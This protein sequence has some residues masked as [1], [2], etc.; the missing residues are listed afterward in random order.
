MG[1]IASLFFATNDRQIATGALMKQ[2]G[3]GQ[4]VTLGLST[5]S[6]PRG[7]EAFRFF[8]IG[9]PWDATQTP[10]ADEKPHARRMRCLR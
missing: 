4:T 5:Q 9:Y 7:R 6:F 3:L 1:H 10:L 2:S 8:G